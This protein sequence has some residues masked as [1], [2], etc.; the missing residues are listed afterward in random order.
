[1]FP[2]IP[3]TVCANSEGCGLQAHLSLHLLFAY[4]LS[5]AFMGWLNYTVDL[6]FTGGGSD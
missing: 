3:Y 2:L 4:V 6:F 5:T 1:M